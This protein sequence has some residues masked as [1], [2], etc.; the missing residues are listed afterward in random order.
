MRTTRLLPLLALAALA[1]P[2]AAAQ[3]ATI[4]AP[5]RCYRE[6]TKIPVRGSD[7]TPNTAVDVGFQGRRPVTRTTDDDGDFKAKVPVPELGNDPAT[8]RVRLFAEERDNPANADSES[9]QLTPIAVGTRENSFVERGEKIWLRFS[10]FPNGRVIRGH[11]LYGGQLRGHQ[12]FGE[13]DG[14]CGV[15]RA[16]KA[17]IPR[18]VDRQGTWTIQFDA[19]RKYS[20]R[21][22]PRIRTKINVVSVPA[23]AAADGVSAGASLVAGGLL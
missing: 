12:R 9:V 18:W 20:R 14:P 17:L 13:A 10:G 4:D 2:V 16:H 5:N 8:G 11:Y 6:H 22:E 23:S 7:F 19:R 1:A 3:A 21:T 15:L